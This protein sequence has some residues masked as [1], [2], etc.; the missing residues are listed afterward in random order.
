MEDFSTAEGLDH[1]TNI[2]SF[3]QCKYQQLPVKDRNTGILLS[4]DILNWWITNFFYSKSHRTDRISLRT[5]RDRDGPVQLGWQY[6]TRQ[7]LRNWTA[8]SWLL[9]S[10]WKQEQ[11]AAQ[12]LQV[13]ISNQGLGY[14][15]LSYGWEQPLCGPLLRNCYFWKLLI[16]I[17][18]MFFCSDFEA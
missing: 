13:P 12:V 4:C 10:L 17:I 1:K 9:G 7:E 2:V 11:K 16:A 6:C 5:I 18:T 14:N 15:P 3:L 8:C